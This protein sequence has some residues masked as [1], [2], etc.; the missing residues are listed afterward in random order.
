MSAQIAS[1]KYQ[2]SCLQL[3]NMVALKMGP[4]TR[5]PGTQYEATFKNPYIDP[6][7][8]PSVRLESFIFSQTT[9]F[10]IEFG[11]MYA[12]F[13]SNGAQ[14]SLTTAPT[15]VSGEIYF[16][17]AFVTDP[18]NSLIYYSAG[19]A[20]STT[21]PHSDST[22][23]VQQSIYEV[24]TP[25]SASYKPSAGQTI[26]D[27]EVFQMQCCQ[28]ND[29]VYIAHRNHPRYKLIRITDTNWT[30]GIVQDSAPPL[31]DQNATDTMIA[32]SG[33]TGT[34]TLT[35]TAPAWVSG[36]FYDEG[37]SVEVSS[38]IYQCQ[39]SHVASVSFA[40]DLANGLWA[41]QVVFQTATAYNSYYQL[42]TRRGT[43]YVE[44]I[45]ATA[46]GIPNGTS[47]TIRCLGKWEVRTYGV[48]SND[49]AVQTSYNNG[50]E[51]ETIRVLTSR[52]DANFDLTPFSGTAI[53]DQIFRLVISNNASP[54]VPGT[55]PPRVIFE[56][57]DNVV[58]GLAQISARISDY[59]ATATVIK[60]F[61]DT[62][63]TP[64]WSE[65]A[66]SYARGFPGSI[67][68]FQQRVFCGGTEFQPQRIWGTVI[69][70]LENWG[71][72]SS[73]T[74]GMAVDIDAVGEG[75][76]CWLAAQTDLY[77][78]MERA[79]FV[80]GP[81]DTTLAF[82]ATNIKA[83]RQS[84]YGSNAYVR[85]LVVGDALVYPQ[86]QGLTLRQMVFT[87]QTNKYMSE[88]LTQFSDS[89]M[90]TGVV[91]LA[92][93]KQFQ[94]NGILW[95][96]TLNGELV[97][98]TYE[99]GVG[100]YGWHR[101][102]TGIQ[103]SDRFESVA[104]VPGSGNSDDEVWVAV[105]RTIAESSVIYIER[106]NPINW[107]NVNGSPQKN[108]AFYVDCGTT[109]TFPSSNVFTGLSQL[110]TMPVVASVNGQIFSDPSMVV[111]GGSV[112]IPNFTPTET[113]IVHIGLPYTSILQPMN[114]DVDGRAGPTQGLEKKITGITLM[115]YN[116]LACT[117]GDGVNNK[118]ISFRKGF[119]EPA[120]FTGKKKIKDFPGDTALDNPIIIQTS[121][122]L[123]LTVLGISVSYDITGTP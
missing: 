121:D 92:Y 29:V 2:S 98:M 122:P 119:G 115:L 101:H 110:E 88:D 13:Y 23:W 15:W 113:E 44:V 14:V 6:S 11:N 76:I 84:G 67:T 104:V 102:T 109:F 82:S 52:G 16:P 89:I 61:Y 34:I 65:G 43:T 8:A 60:P 41:V 3:R 69:D 94:R 116:T 73:S 96:T 120:L 97:G 4:A 53:V 24:P 39:V 57:L 80:I 117:Y 103:G 107:Q 63:P 59:Q 46:T 118:S 20:T 54:T 25:Y 79:E 95:A 36:T 99:M 47:S 48:W 87:F 37:R 108:Q 105:R 85:G 42:G 62:N 33:T 70:D 68:T 17:G 49:I 77:C 32:P 45:G 114:L 81:E 27:S 12:R 58:Y 22:N 10:V 31:L 78:G 83:R 1:P 91:Q 112:T 64:I 90:N 5:R 19:G 18:T 30:M 35:A 7:K 66:W 28:I 72:G 100:V 26:R 74:D 106:I 38:V 71:L 9:S 123:P 86:A 40:T 21:Q 55:I 93:Q 50:A 51:W 75:R 56:C 111:S